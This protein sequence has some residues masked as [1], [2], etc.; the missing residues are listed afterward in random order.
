[1][2]RVIEQVSLT[3][4]GWR[5]RQCI[6][7]GSKGGQA[8]PPRGGAKRHDVNLLINAGIYRDRSLAEPAL[9]A[10]IQEDIG[11][12][13]ERRAQTGPRHVLIRYFKR[14]L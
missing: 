2:A 14:I 3:D 10:M 13:T 9:A 1:M 11:A 12:N 8:L 6:P 4:G 5:T 7:F